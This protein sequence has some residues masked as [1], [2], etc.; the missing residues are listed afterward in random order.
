MS[1]ASADLRC[2][3]KHFLLLRD[4]TPSKGIAGESLCTLPQTNCQLRKVSA[5]YA[6]EYNE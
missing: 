2:R 4:V 6:Q 5:Y 1:L 3:F